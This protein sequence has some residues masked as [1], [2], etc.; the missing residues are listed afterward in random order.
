M[1][2]FMANLQVK[3]ID[4]KLYESLGKRAAM[5]NR[6]ISQEVIFILKEYLSTP[7]RK[8][9]KTND[10]FLELC[11]SWEDDKSADKIVTQI[12]KDRIRRTHREIDL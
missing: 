7:S 12:R 10:Q 2:E 4:D 11:G 5:E 6:S 9:Q 1:E 3:S 8:H